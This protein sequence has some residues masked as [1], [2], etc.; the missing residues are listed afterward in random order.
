M[1]SFPCQ[2]IFSK[3]NGSFFLLSLAIV[4]PA[5]RA[6]CILPLGSMYVFPYACMH[7]VLYIFKCYRTHTQ[8]R[9]GKKKEEEENIM[10]RIYL[11]GKEDRKPALNEKFE[12]ITNSI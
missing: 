7:T 10:R 2:I 9:S 3:G 8:M 4:E 11:Y 6:Y 1:F 12:T 5:F